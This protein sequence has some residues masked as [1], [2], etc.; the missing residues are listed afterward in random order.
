MFPSPERFPH[1]PKLEDKRNTQV[2]WTTQSTPRIQEEL[3]TFIYLVNKGL[4]N[5]CYAQNSHATQST[6]HT[7]FP[8]Y[9]FP[10][11]YALYALYLKAS[12]TIYSQVC[13]LQGSPMISYFSGHSG[14]F[15]PPYSPWSQQLGEHPSYAPTFCPHDAVTSP[16]SCPIIPWSRKTM[17]AT[18]SRSACPPGSLICQLLLRQLLSH[19]YAL[20]SP[21]SKF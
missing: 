20:D 1:F 18:S 21:S 15:S 6:L 7:I 8:L 14:A 5:V 9:A 10:I 13:K 4:H 12:T 3:S 19:S 2:D 16:T 11:S 17:T